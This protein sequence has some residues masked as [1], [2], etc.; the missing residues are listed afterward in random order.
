MDSDATKADA[1]SVSAAFAQLLAPARLSQFDTWRQRLDEQLS[2]SDATAA[3]G[4]LR[5]LSAHAD[6]RTRDQLL[7]ALM[8]TRPSADSASVED[9]LARLLLLLQRD[10]YLLE[11]D[12]RYAF[13]SFLLRE[14]WQR[15][16]I[17]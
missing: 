14:Y 13:R 17:R 11:H 3:K 9:Q 8:L 6:G 12:R 5:H 1:S 7:N 10:G 15:R 2:P 4:I 16:E